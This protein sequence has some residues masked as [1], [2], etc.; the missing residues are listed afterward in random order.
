MHT[1]HVPHMNQVCRV[2]L[3]ATGLYYIAELVEECSQLAK[4]VITYTVEVCEPVRI[5]TL[6]PA[7][8]PQ[9]GN[10]PC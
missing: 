2:T 1:I 3:A 7:E 8:H 4:R 10:I 9:Q 6:P 5:I